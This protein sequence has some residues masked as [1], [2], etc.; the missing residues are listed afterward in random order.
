MLSME[1]NTQIGMIDKDNLH[2]EKVS[3][4][5]DLNEEQSLVDPM[6]GKELQITEDEVNPVG[7]VEETIKPEVVRVNDD[8]G[9]N[10]EPLW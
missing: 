10:L 7:P 4:D 3:L 6:V 8:F 1:T 5:V 9:F 2:E